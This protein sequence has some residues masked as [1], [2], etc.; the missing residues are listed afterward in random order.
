MSDFAL[1]S[2]FHRVLAGGLFAGL[3]G[4]ALASLP[5]GGADGAPA[6]KAAAAKAA[7]PKAAA[8]KAAT[9]KAAAIEKAPPPIPNFAPESSV[10]W[11][12]AATEFIALPEGPHPVTSD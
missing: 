2:P 10:G 1:K 5:A 4:A 6:P 12:A 8:S 9:G 3:L 7:A 11:L